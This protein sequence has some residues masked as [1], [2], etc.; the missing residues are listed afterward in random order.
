LRRLLLSVLLGMPL[1][2]TVNV[3][4]YGAQGDGLAND[5]V[6]LNAA[7]SAA[8]ADSD[9]VYIPA[10]MYSTNSLD[11]LI[12]CRVTFH[13]DGN[14][15][16]ILKFR[17]VLA[18]ALWR[19]TAGS[20]KAL[21]IQDLAL[22][23][24]HLPGAGLSIEQY[25]A[26]TISRVVIHNFGMPGYALGHKSPYD[27]LYIR[28]VENVRIT[29]SE[30]TGNERAGVELQAVHNST[31]SNSVMSG[32]GG[33]GGVSEQNFE[34]PLDGPLVAQWLDNTLL[35]NGSGGIDVE[36][37]PKLQPAQAIL[38]GNRVIDC[39]NNKWDSGWGLV[40]G[41]HS[42][43]T[44]IGNSVEYFAFY[45]SPSNYGNAIVYGRNGGPISILNNTVIGT[46][47]YAIVGD[48][49]AFPVTISGNT[50]SNNGTGIFI[51]RSP[52]VRIT[53]NTVTNSAGPGIDV[54]WSNENTITGNQLSGNLTNLKIN[55]RAIQRY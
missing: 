36:T 22:D 49:G 48:Q 7:F 45:A 11:N 42:F 28:N 6:A 12:G 1:W 30:F 9:D 17:S 53:N 29:N 23:G 38:Q 32:N 10:G 44:I 43:G 13:G 21:T 24:G 26:V 19:F 15:R 46:K 37:D 35:E 31:V 40:I 14:N 2:A 47:L 8:C 51:Y 18:P 34:G 3:R 16:S 4:E 20:G 27:G 5:T 54:F 39:G 50:L 52:R 41:L 55:G 25:Q 33:M